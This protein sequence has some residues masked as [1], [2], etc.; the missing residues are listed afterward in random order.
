MEDET[1]VNDVFQKLFK[2]PTKLMDLVT[3]VGSKLDTKIKSGDLKESELLAEAAE[4]MQHMKDMPGM[5]NIQN[6]FNKAGSDKM[7]TSAM[8]AQMKRNINLAKQ[9]ERMRSKIS[10]TNVKPIPEVNI[11]SEEAS[12]QAAI[13]LLLSE[14]VKFEDMENVIFSTG[15]AYEKSSRKQNTDSESEPKKKKKKKK[16]KQNK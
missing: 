11:E 4:M 16:K 9:K 12:N 5:E 2:N 14:G 10:K 13:D 15:E 6:L 7:N 3:K 8:Q 1:S